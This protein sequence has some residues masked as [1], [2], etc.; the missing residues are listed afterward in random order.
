MATHSGLKLSSPRNRRERTRLKRAIGSLRMHYVVLQLLLLA[1]EAHGKSPPLVFVPR[2]QSLVCLLLM[3]L[4]VQR[5]PLAMHSSLVHGY[6][7]ELP[8]DATWLTP[9]GAY[10]G[11]WP[12]H[13]AL[14]AWPLDG[15]TLLDAS[16]LT[17]FL[18]S[19]RP[20]AALATVLR[21]PP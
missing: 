6:G 3:A 20:P 14:E 13:A 12:L 8:A 7:S 16:L 18:R 21:H 4:L 9:E 2:P 11:L 10:L 17:A 15:D 19:R 5:A 1:E